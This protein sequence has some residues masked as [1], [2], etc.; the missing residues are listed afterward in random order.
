MF[1]SAL[2]SGKGGEIGKQIPARLGEFGAPH[3]SNGNK[4]AHQ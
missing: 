3:H 1:S 4:G 2:N